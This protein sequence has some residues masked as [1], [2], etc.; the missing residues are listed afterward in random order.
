ML[1]HKWFAIRLLLATCLT[2]GLAAGCNESSLDEEEEKG[3]LTGVPINFTASVPTTA[4]RA[5][6]TD[7]NTNNLMSMGV[8]ASYTGQEDYLNQPFNFMSGQRVSRASS[9][10][11][12]T[13]SPVKYW[14]NNSGDKISFFAYAPYVDDSK[15][16]ITL[17]GQNR[18]YFDIQFK[19]PAK[20]SE[21]VGIL[22]ADPLK[23]KQKGNPLKFTFRQAF[24][25]IEFRVK[26]EFNITV[27]ELKVFDVW[28]NGTINSDRGFN[29]ASPGL[30]PVVADRLLPLSIYGYDPQEVACFY[31]PGKESNSKVH[32]TYEKLNVPSSSMTKEID[33]PNG[34]SWVNPGGDK[35]ARHIIYT[36]TIDKNMAIMVTNDT[37]WRDGSEVES[38][39]GAYD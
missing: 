9:A 31:L 15:G 28:M 35:E 11:P 12:W 17:I 26:S 8:F 27:T 34:P 25:K 37:A 32:I 30:K 33:F 19:I 36:I 5:T 14:S 18:G 3:G 29:A 7:F 23:N 22:I 39:C 20:E 6:D 24:A 13:Y 38:N 2:A 1:Q 21:Q 4:A 10:A 16:I